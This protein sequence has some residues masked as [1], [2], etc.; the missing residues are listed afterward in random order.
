MC[1][2]DE[3]LEKPTYNFGSLDETIEL[4]K[5]KSEY[6]SKKNNAQNTSDNSDED[7]ILELEL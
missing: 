1:K 2:K 5:L 3:N 7:K 6:L 4:A